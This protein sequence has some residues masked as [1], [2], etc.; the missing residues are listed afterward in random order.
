MHPVCGLFHVKI[1][2]LNLADLLDICKSFDI[3][4]RNK[5]HFGHPSPKEHDDL[6]NHV[7]LVWTKLTPAPDGKMADEPRYRY[8]DPCDLSPAN[9]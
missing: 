6:Y 8:R 9:L 4:R 3:N 5:L 7:G 1:T 2:P